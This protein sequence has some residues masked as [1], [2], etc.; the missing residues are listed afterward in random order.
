MAHELSCQFEDEA[1]SGWK[2]CSER[3]LETFEEVGATAAH[4]GAVGQSLSAPQAA[5]KANED[6]QQAR[7]IVQGVGGTVVIMCDKYGMRA[8]ETASIVKRT[9]T[10]WRLHN[11]VGL[12]RVQLGYGW[13]HCVQGTESF[14]EKAYLA[15]ELALQRQAEALQ[16]QAEAEAVPACT[17]HWDGLNKEQRRQATRL[18]FGRQSWIDDDWRDVPCA[19]ESLKGELRAAA[20]A[21]GFT[22]QA[23]KGRNRS[24]KPTCTKHWN[25][26]DKNERRQ[27]ILLGFGWQ[28]W[29]DDDWSGVPCAWDRLS[30]ERLAAASALGFTQRTWKGADRREGADMRE[31]ALGLSSGLLLS[32]AGRLSSS[33]PPDAGAP[34]PWPDPIDSRGEHLPAWSI[35]PTP[36]IFECAVEG[37]GEGAAIASRL[38]SDLSCQI[39][40]AIEELAEAEQR[41][42]R[43]RMGAVQRISHW[44]QVCWQA[45]P[46]GHQLSPPQV[47]LIGS[48][49][50]NLAVEM[51]DIDLTV[52][53][54]RS[55]QL[56]SSDRLMAL[57]RILKASRKVASPL[58]RPTILPAA[59]VPIVKFRE[60]KSGLNVDVSVGQAD[61]YPVTTLEPSSRHPAA[62]ALKAPLPY[63]CPCP[64][65]LTQTHPR[66]PR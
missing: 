31:G 27:A 19:W 56:G 5:K 42:Q 1:S 7:G 23:W 50:T 16:R 25:G 17:K 26:L 10:A 35:D 34:D 28:T 60:A 54:A 65:S 45:H 36:S 30:C 21:L 62:P 29:I 13:A 8:G 12:P 14:S 40:D 57:R 48:A 33:V 49:C 43:V 52:M 4:Q 6:S 64:A 20:S 51:S 22:Q 61:G 44:I 53:P 18:G 24:A 46:G 39:A 47:H 66:V 15:I 59:K 3:T 58:P 63:L 11:G 9:G 38:R 41:R 55:D 2:V 32:P 37:G